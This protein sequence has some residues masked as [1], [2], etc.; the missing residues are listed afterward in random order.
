[1]REIW[2]I[3]ACLALVKATS[4]RFSAAIVTPDIVNGFYRLQ[5]GFPS[6]PG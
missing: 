2:V 6:S 3:A 4:R 5:G 1:M